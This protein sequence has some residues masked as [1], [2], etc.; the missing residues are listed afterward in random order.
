VAALDAAIS[1][2]ILDLLNAFSE[3]M[4]EAANSAAILDLLRAL[5]TSSELM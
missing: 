2:S 4:R 1:A 5:S 3:A